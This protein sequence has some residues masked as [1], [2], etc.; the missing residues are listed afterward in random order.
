MGRKH[1][2]EAKHIRLHRLG[3]AAD[4]FESQ[5]MLTGRQFVRS[6]GNRHGG[7]DG[8]GVEEIDTAAS[9]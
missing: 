2:I 7:N 1:V 8:G 4:N 9:D 6:E 5:A 3:I